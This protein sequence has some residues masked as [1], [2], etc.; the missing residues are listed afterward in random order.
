MQN[1][2]NSLLAVYHLLFDHYG[3]QH[4]W[5][6]E[7]P[8]E[9]MV[10]AILTQNTAWSNVEKAIANL[11]AHDKLNATAIAA[12]RK[13]QLAGWLRPSGY[14]NVK[15]TR[16]KHFC[17]WY[18]QAGGFSRLSETA[19]DE[20]RQMLL[21]VNGIGRETADDILLYAFQR[22]VFVIDA[23]TRRLFTRLELFDGT[24]DYDTMRGA[25][26]SALGPDVALFNEYHALIVR[27]GKELCRVRPRCNECLMLK[28]CPA[29][30]GLA[31]E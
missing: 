24:E 2:G 15:A 27:H 26:E 13:E 18:Y 22:P 9:V 1:T 31:T 21:S 3:P 10:G 11:R 28:R 30:D 6:G 16:L 17:R 23:Y 20:L 8:F 29:G 12:V 5:P 14:F 25:I 7:T 4:W 19:T